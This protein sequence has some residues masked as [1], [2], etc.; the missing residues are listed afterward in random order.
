MNTEY[1]THIWVNAS[2]HAAAAA[3]GGAGGA[4]VLDM[5]FYCIQ[6]SW[7][8]IYVE[9]AGQNVINILLLLSVRW[10]RSTEYE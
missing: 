10:H 5:F 7:N 6:S 4:A 2:A 8:T 9:V 3:A 1:P